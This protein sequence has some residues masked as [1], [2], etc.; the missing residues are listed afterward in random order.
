MKTVCPNCNQEYDVEDNFLQQEV[1]CQVCNQDFIVHKA[2]FCADCGAVN[3]AQAFNCKQCGKD[4]P[5]PKT[6]PTRTQESVSV[7]HRPK[8]RVSSAESI[9]RM[10]KWGFDILILSLFAPIVIAFILLVNNSKN[11]PIYGPVVFLIICV[12]YLASLLPALRTYP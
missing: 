11:P 8:H 2:K 12:M 3:P 7:P 4:F 6:I 10:T 9:S 5:L 1:T